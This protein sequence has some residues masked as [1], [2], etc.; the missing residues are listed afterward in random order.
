[1]YRGPDAEEKGDH[2]CCEEADC[3]TSGGLPLECVLG[4]FGTIS[5]QNSRCGNDQKRIDY[6]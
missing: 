3:A 1:M 2:T 6:E 5:E 4:G